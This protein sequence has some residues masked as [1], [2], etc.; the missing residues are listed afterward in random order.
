MHRL[1]EPFRTKAHAYIYR[2]LIGKIVQ[3]ARMPFSAECVPVVRTAELNRMTAWPDPIR[4]SGGCRRRRPGRVVRRC[5]KY[6]TLDERTSLLDEVVWTRTNGQPSIF[7][8]LAQPDSAD[9]IAT[10]LEC[11]DPQQQSTVSTESGAAKGRGGL[12]PPESGCGQRK[13][14]SRCT[15]KRCGQRKGRSRR[16]RKRGR[17]KEGAVSVHRCLI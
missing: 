10:V 4:V 5:L 15:R 13:G 6:G 12:G 2:R 17:P 1:P 3:L 7:T 14:R 16:T 11:A 9:L 8:L